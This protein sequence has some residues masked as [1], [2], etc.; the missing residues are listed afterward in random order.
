MKTTK[1]GVVK[2]IEIK[3]N[4]TE[5][6][7]N[8]DVDNSYPQRVTDIINS[9]G[10]GTLCTDMMGKFIY[11]VGFNDKEFGKLVVNNEGLTANQLLRMV[12]RSM[13]YFNGFTL[14]TNFTMDK[15]SE[16]NFQPF[17]HVRK[18]N[19][20]NKDHLN[21]LAIYNDWQKINGRIDPKKK[22]Y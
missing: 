9:S 21:Q 4:K 1:T 22:D 10:T 20:E 12:S 18:T 14:H 16:V 7:D 13:S 15:I 17:E 6:I 2:R 8:F 11:G 3:P 5:G 19:K